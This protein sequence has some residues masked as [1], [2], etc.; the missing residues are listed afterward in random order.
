V[1][2][3]AKRTNYTVRFGKDGRTSLKV[4]CNRGAGSWKLGG[5]GEIQLGMLALTRA[6]CPT[7]PL[8]NKLPADWP[9]LNYFRIREDHLFLSIKPTGSFYEF[10]AVPGTEPWKR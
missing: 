6:A 1:L 8:T 9:S 5:F 10:E 7:H 2:T 4:D 3:P